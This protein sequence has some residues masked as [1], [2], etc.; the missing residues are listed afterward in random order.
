ME[1]SISQAWPLSSGNADQELVGF[2]VSMKG[3][4]KQVSKGRLTM[5]SLKTKYGTVSSKLMH[6]YTI[7]KYI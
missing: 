4:W 2:T 7:K 6:N 5:C 1:Q 3:F